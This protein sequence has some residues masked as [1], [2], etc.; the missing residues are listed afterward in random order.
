MARSPRRAPTVH[1][2]EERLTNVERE[3][4]QVV[5]TVTSINQAATSEA[6][7]V[8]DAFKEHRAEVRKGFADTAAG[9]G[10]LRTDVVSL[11]TDVAAVQSDVT[12]VRQDIDEILRRVSGRD[13]GE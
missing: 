2:L 9:L 7:W 5:S 10:T 1:D 11:R 8:R 12:A 3:L 4:A 6:E 13:R